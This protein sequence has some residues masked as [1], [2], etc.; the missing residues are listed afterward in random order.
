VSQ[1]PVGG[2]AGLERRAGLLRDIR[3]FFSDLE[4]LEVDTPL[5]GVAGAT[6]PAIESFT[7]A[8]AGMPLR[9]LQTSPEFAMKRLLAAGSGDIY[10][11]CHAF[12][13][14]ETS[15]LHREEFSLLEWYR[16]G[17]DHNRLMDD[18]SA[19]L[20]AVRFPFPVTRHAY[21]E[22]CLTHAGV[23]PMTASTT[24]LAEAAAAAGARLGAGATD[25]AL[26]LDWLFGCAV[27]PALP[28]AEAIFIFDF[29][30]EQAAYARIR[31]GDPPVG[32]RF[33]LVLGE[34]E[35]A[36]GFHEVTDAREQHARHT[37]ENLRREALGLPVVP[38]DEALL[39]A[40]ES[41]LPPC[42]GVAL[43][44]DRLLMVLAGVGDIRDVVGLDEPPA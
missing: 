4:V 14:E 17:F 16:L 23:D 40:L 13:R 21:R 2:R 37:R 19:L 44:L 3:A 29:P 34:M 5:L 27:L 30:V 42:A 7:V 8:A 22:L 18:V 36:N 39:A 9:Y 6:D 26:L 25:R 12:R 10:Q 1:Q 38:L 33:E 31:P 32:E 41:G 20:E 24:T 43:G 35:L 15:R 11:I 28:R